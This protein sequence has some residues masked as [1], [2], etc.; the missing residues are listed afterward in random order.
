[1]AILFV[2][3]VWPHKNFD[4]DSIVKIIRGL[5]KETTGEEINIQQ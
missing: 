3:V 5:V 4:K 2:I 1:M